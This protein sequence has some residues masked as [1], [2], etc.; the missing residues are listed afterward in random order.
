MSGLTNGPTAADGKIVPVG[1]GIGED[2]TRPVSP[3]IAGLVVC[4]IG[5]FVATTS[6]AI[7]APALVAFGLV[8]CAP[9]GLVRE[10]LLGLVVSLAV[11]AGGILL[12]GAEFSAD[13]LYDA[14]EVI[15]AAAAA[16]AVA[17]ALVRGRLTPGAICIVMAALTACHLA[18]DA[19]VVS[20][21]G[22]T[23]PQAVSQLIADLRE[24]LSETSATTAAQMESTLSL[25]E[26]LWPSGYVMAALVEGLMALLGTWLAA[27]QR[28]ELAR[29]RLAD[30]DLPLWVVTALV[31]SVAGLAVAYTF[32]GAPDAVLLVS[33]NLAVALRFAFTAQGAGVIV[34]F[35]DHKGVGTVGRALIALLGLY[36][37]VQ[38]IVVSIVGLVDVWANFRHLQGGGRPG[39]AGTAEQDKE[40]A[41][42]G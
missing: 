3:R 9:R 41:N 8:S 23:L 2:G 37:E 24:Q 31:V 14:A 35:L 28:K 4:G 26:V 1:P 33:A 40:P 27:S 11:A 12:T 7:L 20:A 17:L 21:S 39:S 34:W 18:L 16:F 30:F 13:G 38:F 36:L 10:M 32:S 6:L 19:L 25:L 29:P 22:V 15:I 5:G 42:A